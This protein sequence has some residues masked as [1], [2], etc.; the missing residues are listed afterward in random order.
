[1]FVAE[2]M[3]IFA[4]GGGSMGG[5]LGLYVCCLGKRRPDML[6]LRSLSRPLLVGE[7]D[8]GTM[9]YFTNLLEF[10]LGCRERI[11]DD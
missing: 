2:H 11:R 10:M 5:R 7:D 3:P 9:V 1:M 6:G 8:R 4:N